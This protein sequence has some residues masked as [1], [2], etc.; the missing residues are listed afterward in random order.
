M[1]LD[2]GWKAK[3]VENLLL[4]EEQKEEKKYLLNQVFKMINFNSLKSHKNEFF[5]F[6]NKYNIFP[7]YHF[8][9]LYKFSIHKKKYLNKFTGAEEYAKNSVSLPVYF[10][11][12]KN[13]ISYIIK[14]IKKFIQSNIKKL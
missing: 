10:D 11:L 8:I 5:K 7:Q 2:L 13:D 12:N 3:A 9:P 14:V 4:E 1:D 6:L